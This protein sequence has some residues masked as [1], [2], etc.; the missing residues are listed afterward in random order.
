MDEGVQHA[1]Q[2]VF[3]VSE[4]LHSDLASNP[5]DTCEPWVGK[6][7]DD[8]WS[9]LTFNTSDAE[10]VDDVLRQS[11]GHAFWGLQLFALS[12]AG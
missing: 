6:G 1:H 3:V 4:K 9:S 5:E 2:C 12:N 11:E 8:C 7:E 10:P